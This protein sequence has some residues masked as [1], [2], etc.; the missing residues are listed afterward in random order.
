MKY[1]PTIKYLLDVIGKASKSV[2]RD[3][4]ELVYMQNSIRPTADF[5][6]KSRK[7]SADLMLEEISNQRKYTPNIA[8]EDQVKNVNNKYTVIIEPLDGLKNFQ[9]A[10]PLFT[11]AASLKDEEKGEVIATV[12]EVPALRE[13][14]FAEKNNGAWHDSFLNSASSGSR[15][16][17]SKRQNIADMYFSSE[18]FIPEMA[19]NLFIAHSPL[20]SIAM[21][22][23]G[24]LDACIFKEENASSFLH[25]SLIAEEAGGESFQINNLSVFAT[26]TAGQELKVKLGSK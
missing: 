7:R 15:L 6:K 20:L 5:V 17:V 2:L 8:F 21:L 25:A 14:Y 12:I 4:N 10:I 24:S 13:V 16:R 23:S 22:S 9:R 26:N 1:S 19:D 18:V 3:Y 11:I